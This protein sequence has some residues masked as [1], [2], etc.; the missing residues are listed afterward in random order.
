MTL[1]ELLCVITLLCILLS[2]LLA[3]LAQA[4]QW[5][6][7]WIVGAYAHRENQIEAFCDDR[8]PESLL[9]RWSTNRPVRWTYVELERR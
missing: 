6:R 2:M 9:L 1:V 5:C 7:E 3:V 8:A 4:Q